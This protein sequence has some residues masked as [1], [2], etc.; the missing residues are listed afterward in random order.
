MNVVEV[1]VIVGGCCFL[2]FIVAM[3][4]EDFKR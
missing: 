3:I 1:F 2:M 4:V